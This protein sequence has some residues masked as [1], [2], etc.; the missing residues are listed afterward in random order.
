MN[1]KVP[2]YQIPQRII[3]MMNGEPWQF[4]FD[5]ACI[6]FLEKHYGGNATTMEMLH[7]LTAYQQQVLDDLKEPIPLAKFI[8]DLMPPIIDPQVKTTVDALMAEVAEKQKKARANLGNATQAAT[9]ESS[10]PLV[11]ALSDAA[12]SGESSSA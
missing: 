6:D 7:S 8:N 12:T 5:N 11:S 4:R 1:N 2:N 10:S 9:Q 3:T